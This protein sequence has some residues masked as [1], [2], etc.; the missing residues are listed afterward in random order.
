MQVSKYV[1]L[2]VSR[3]ASYRFILQCFLLKYF[4]FC[5]LILATEDHFCTW[6]HTM[7]HTRSVGLLWTTDR[8]VA[9]AC[10]CTKHNI[11]QRHTSIPEAGFEHAISAS[12]RLQIYVLDC[13]AS[14]ICIVGTQE[15]NTRYII[16]SLVSRSYFSR[17]S[18]PLTP[19]LVSTT[20][21]KG[22]HVSP[23]SLQLKI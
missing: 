22:H 7:T 6:S 17:C 21:N 5:L 13:G 3:L 14:G 11:Q 4:L 16:M 1:L 10:T 18:G 9:E 19:C 2:K 23:R 12:E 15:L 20:H 8:R